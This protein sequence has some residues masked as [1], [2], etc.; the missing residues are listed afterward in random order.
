MMRCA[1]LFLAIALLVGPWGAPSAPAAGYERYEISGTQVSPQS[2]PYTRMSWPTFCHS[3]K[4]A[5]F[6]EKYPDVLDSATIFVKDVLS[7][8]GLAEH[9]NRP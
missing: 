7:Q 9:P 2:R 3:V 8:F 1:A 5:T 4:K 6:A